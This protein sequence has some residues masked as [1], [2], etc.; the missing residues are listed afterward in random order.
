MAKNR[1]SKKEALRNTSA[2]PAPRKRSSYKTEEAYINAVYRYNKAYIDSHMDPELLAKNKR[3]GPRAY[4]LD[5]VKRVRK[6]QNQMKDKHYT[7]RQALKRVSNSLI[8]NPTMTKSD[9]KANNFESL[10]KKDKE[11]YKEFRNRTRDEKKRFTKFDYSKVE[12]KGYYVYNGSNAAVYFYDN[13][14]VVIEYKSPQQGTGASYEVT[15]IISF[16]KSLGVTTFGPYTA[17]E[18]KS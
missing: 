10:L 3:N 11:I 6:L 16:N 5:E 7:L 2:L 13:D 15:D 18:M 9:I 1:R 8:L 4:F 12:F 14:T 17:K